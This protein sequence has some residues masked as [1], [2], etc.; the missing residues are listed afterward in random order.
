MKVFTR[1]NNERN[2]GKCSITISRSFLKYKDICGGKNCVELP[3][4]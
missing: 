3:Y 2:D 1:N 4:L